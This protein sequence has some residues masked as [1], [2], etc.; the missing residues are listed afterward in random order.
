MMYDQTTPLAYAQVIPLTP[1]D[2]N[3]V[4]Y[5]GNSNGNT[6][7]SNYKSSSSSASSSIL[8][9]ESIPLNDSQMTRLMEQGFTRGK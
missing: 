8:Q 5:H 9:R 1:E 7:S 3:I 4:N 2:N 6:H